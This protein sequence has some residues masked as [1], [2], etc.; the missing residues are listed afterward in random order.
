MHQGVSLKTILSLIKELIDNSSVIIGHNLS[1]DEN[2]IGAELL[3]AGIGY[4]LQNKTKICTMESSVDLC[5]IETE[6]GY[7]Y[8]KL[9]ELYYFLFNKEL[10][11]AHNAA[12]DVSAT[13]K[14]FWE[15]KRR[16][17]I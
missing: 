11:D 1:F 10:K 2:I 16:G 9:S 3:R 7:K 6:L 12:I 4:S 8:P 15:L 5:C 17:L 13:V 14:C